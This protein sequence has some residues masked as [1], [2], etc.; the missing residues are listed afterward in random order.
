MPGRP[1]KGS[2]LKASWSKP[3]QLATF[4]MEE[5]RLYSEVPLDIKLFTL[6]LSSESRCSSQ[7]SGIMDVTSLCSRLLVAVMVLLVAQIKQSHSAQNAGE[8]RPRITPDRLQF[9]EYETVHI[10]CEEL[11]GLTGW[12]VMHRHNKTTN[13]SICTPPASRCTIQPAFEW[14]SGEFWCE[15]DEGNTTGSINISVTD[16]SVILEVPARPVMEGSNVTLLCQKQNSESKYIVD[17]YKDGVS[18]WSEYSHLTIKNVSKSHEGLYKC[19]IS[20][21]GQSPESWLAVTENT[22]ISYKEFQPPQQHPSNFPTQTFLVYC[23]ENHHHKKIK[24][25][26]AQKH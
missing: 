15:D 24:Q 23:L 5:Q 26:A 16:G 2:N 3:P 19:S 8:A 22:N 7:Q 18:L 11:M 21:A 4:K 12:R 10:S 1:P 20:G 13:S 6:F 25:I 17:F 14:D 9:F